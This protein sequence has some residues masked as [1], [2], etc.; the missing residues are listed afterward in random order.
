MSFDEA[1]PSTAPTFCQ[2]GRPRAIGW[3]AIESERFLPKSS[4]INLLYHPCF[5]LFAKPNLQNAI[6]E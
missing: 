2:W 1:R 6:G 5:D 4:K 3:K